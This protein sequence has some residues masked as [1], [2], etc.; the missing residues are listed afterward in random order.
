MKKHKRVLSLALALVMALALLSTGAMAETGNRKPSEVFACLPANPAP[1]TPPTYEEVLNE[2]YGGREEDILI[3]KELWLEEYRDMGP[4]DVY[5]EIVSLVNSLTKGKTSETA[6]AKAIYQWVANNISYTSEAPSS[7]VYVYASRKTL[8][9]GYTWL[10]SL[11]QRLAGLPAAEIISWPDNHEWSAVYADGRWI[12]YDSTNKGWDFAPDAGLPLRKHISEMSYVDGNSL[13]KWTIINGDE[14]ID[15]KARYIGGDKSSPE[16]VVVPEGVTVMGHAGIPRSVTSII[17]PSTLK[18]IE[19]RAF[20]GYEN[21]TSIS[22]PESVTK[23]EHDAFFRC[24]SLK[25]VWFCGT[26]EQ[27]DAIEIDI[28]NDALENAAVHYNSVP[29]TGTA[30]ASNITVNVDGKPVEFQCYALHDA[31]GNP[32]NYIKLRD[33]ADVLNGT[34]AQFEVG[35]DGSALITT[36]RAYT[37]NGSEHSTPFSGNR[38]YKLADNS[39]KIN[40]ETTD[41]AAFMLYDDNGGGYTYYQLRDLG[42]KLG[43]NVGWA[44][45]R[46]IFVETDK[47]YD[48][49]N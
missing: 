48:A 36:K 32:T 14:A 43:F 10:S 33:L 23:I 12:M 49:N 8:C 41:L 2:W 7:P 21:L 11:M 39:T 22:V 31:N 29:S 47:P 40:G 34:Q 6:K 5:T 45:D 18:K 44:A 20:E 30:Y 37:P 3:F 16:Q 26:K 9:E 46:G 35:F 17:L 24:S 13:W 1:V 19:N 38:T 4:K 42:E 28:G 27:W 15:I 25:D